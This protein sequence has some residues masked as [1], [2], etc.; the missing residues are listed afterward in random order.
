[1]E[2]LIRREFAVILMDV[3]MPDM[4]GFETAEYVRKNKRSMRTPIIFTTAGEHQFT[5]QSRGYSVG[6]VDYIIK[7][8]DPDM[9]RS[10]VRVFLD[11]YRKGQEIAR[12]A[13]QLAQANSDLRIAYRE[14][15]VVAYTVAHDLRAPLRAMAGFSQIL[16]ED[17][18]GKALDGPGLKHTHRIEA[19][20]RQMDA[21]IQSLL[22][23]CRVAGSTVE[24]ERVDPNDLIQSALDRATEGR[25]G[26]ADIAVS[27]SM[28]P[29][30]GHRELLGQTLET[31]LSN[32]L[33]FTEIGRRP[34]IRVRS[35]LRKDRVRIW[36]EDD[37][38]GIAPEHHA[39][40]FN[41]F[42]RLQPEVYDGMG[43]GLAMTKASMERMGG[44]IGLESSPGK[45]SRFWI[46]LRGWDAANASTEPSR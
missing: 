16:R 42:E 37:G 45:G 40:I 29:V 38:V 28:P 8:F 23:Y 30:R 25:P 26:Q 17:Y 41:T 2:I 34:Q 32:A 9:L 6:A 31:L 39:R 21:L 43:M 20:A 10:K 13:E 3:R 35:E 11:L 46:E 18:A 12:K 5:Q 22:S 4:D 24:L 19:S 27:H 36:I 7:P 15:G 33:K 1:M 14:L 44:E